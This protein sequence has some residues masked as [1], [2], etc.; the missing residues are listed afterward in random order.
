MQ[1]SLEVAQ[2]AVQQ[3]QALKDTVASLQKDISTAKEA[4]EVSQVLLCLRD[5]VD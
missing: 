1:A 3:V 2:H 5:G 4:L